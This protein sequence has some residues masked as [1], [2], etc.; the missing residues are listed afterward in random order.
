MGIRELR[1]S[2]SRVIRD[3]CEGTEEIVI[4]VDGEPV[5][6][7]SPLD[8]DGGIVSPDEHDLRLLEEIRDELRAVWP[9]GVTAVEAVSW[10]RS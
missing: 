9:E 8:A 6:T 10:Q 1:D 4:T 3:V 7:L 2:A 5:A